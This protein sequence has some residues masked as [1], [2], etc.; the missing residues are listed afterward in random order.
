MPGADADVYGFWQAGDLVHPSNRGHEM[1]A[2]CLAAYLS[3]A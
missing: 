3:Q 1:V 2:D